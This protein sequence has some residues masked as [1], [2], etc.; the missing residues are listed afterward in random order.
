MLLD[1]NGIGDQDAISLKVYA[2]STTCSA[3]AIAV[4]ELIKRNQSL[5]IIYLGCN[6]IQKV[7]MTALATALTNNAEE[8]KENKNL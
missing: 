2:E 7:G 3:N 4:S 8:V 1:T 6:Y 5:E